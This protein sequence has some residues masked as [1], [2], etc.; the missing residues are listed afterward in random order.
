MI[1]DKS[2]NLYG[3]TQQGGPAFCGIGDQGGCGMVFE[4]S[5]G[6]GGTWTETTLH[7]FTGGDDGGSH[8]AGELVMDSAGNLFG[9]NSYGGVYFFG[10][11][12]FE[13]SPGAGGN[14]TFNVIHSFDGV[15]G[16][17]SIPTSGLTLDS[18]GN[19]YGTGYG[20]VGS[21][22]GGVV[23]KLSPAV[24][25]WT[26]TILHVFTGK[27]DGSAPWGG[28]IFG[29]AGNLYGATWYG[30]K[31]LNCQGSGC[32]TIFKLSPSGLILDGDCAVFIHRCGGW[33]GTASRRDSGR[34][35]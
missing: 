13:L 30:G 22:D 28:V 18:A 31:S 24:G 23:F 20:P 15:D 11:A 3:T 19:L 2:G 33:S 16:D 5:P 7:E 26:T 12:A 4:L 32:G 9:A 6:S 17:V 25:N 1:F 29:S 27:R 21:F 35:G 34:S 8:Y 10:G 14:W